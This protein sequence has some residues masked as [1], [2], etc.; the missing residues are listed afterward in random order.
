MV[1]RVTLLGVSIVAVAIG[2]VGGFVANECDNSEG[3]QGTVTYIVD[4][5]TLDVAG[6]GRVR[7][8]GIDTPERGQCGYSEAKNNLSKL[9][10]NRTVELT[11]TKSDKYGRMIRYVDIG[12]DDAGLDQISAGYAIARYDSRDGYG[13]HAR[14]VNT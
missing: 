7:L 12:E 4:G 13:T 14:E 2:G 1:N 9:T 10:L 5:D 6:I 3:M 8:T 11:G